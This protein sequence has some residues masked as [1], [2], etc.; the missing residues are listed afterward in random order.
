MKSELF[1]DIK[2]NNGCKTFTVKDISAYNPDIPV[3]CGTLRIKV[4]GFN[5]PKYY[6]VLEGF[7]LIV[8]MS[9]LGLQKTWNHE[10]LSALPDG[11]Y[12]I[13][14]SINP[15]DKLFVDYYYYQTCNIYKKYTDAV[16]N[17]LNNKCDLS[18]K[19]QEAKIDDLFEISQ[20]IDYAKISAETCGD[21]DSA[22][23][24][25]NEA[26]EKIKKEGTNG[27]STCR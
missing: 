17:F 11:L 18:K 2:Q 13:R 22:E 4:P 26:L 21:P 5:T 9:N 10:C 20:L 24:M 7:E 27:C 14:Y 1:L 3:T 25:Y 8:N 15:N 12:S 6:D 23:E 19:E 16:C